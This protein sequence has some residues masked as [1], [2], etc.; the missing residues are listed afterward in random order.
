MGVKCSTKRGWA[1][2][3]RCTGGALWV[4]RLSQIT[5]TAR[6]GSVWRSIW[7]R[8]SRK[9]TAR[10]WADSLPITV[11]VAMFSAANKSI[12]PCRTSSKLR[13][14][15]TPGIIGSTGAVR[16]SAWICGFSSTLKTVAFAGG[17]RY[18]PTT[19]RILSISSGSGETLNVSAR[20]GCS[21]NARQM[22]CTL[23][24]EMPT[25]PVTT[26]QPT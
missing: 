4:D 5:W 12:V 2:S 16:S 24:G 3:Q 13:R 23:V 11:P 7:S 17:A 1:S 21:P 18:R 25:S 26:R 15:G 6:A 19:S 14:S 20:H 10:C 8:K 22:R 9:S